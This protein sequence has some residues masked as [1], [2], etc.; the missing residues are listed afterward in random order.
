MKIL[1]RK[2]S[3]LL[4]TEVMSRDIKWEAGSIGLGFKGKI[5]LEFLEYT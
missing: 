1:V 5:N 3:D 4:V 2:E